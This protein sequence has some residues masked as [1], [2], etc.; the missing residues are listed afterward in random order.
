MKVCVYTLALVSAVAVYAPY[1][2]AATLN[3][4]APVTISTGSVTPAMFAVGDFNGD[5]KPDI[6]VPDQ[7]GVTVLVYLNQGRGTFSA[8]V[9]TTL[10]IPNTLGAILAGDFNED[11]K[12]DLLVSTVAGPQVAMPLLSNGDGTFTPQPGIAGSFGFLGG[13]VIDL[14]GDGHKD[15]VL[16]GNGTPYVFFGK[17]DGTFTQQSIPAGSFPGDYFSITVG[18]FRGTKN[19]DVVMA[20]TGD[21][22]GQAGSIDV[23]PGAAGGTLTARTSYTPILITHPETLDSADFNGDGK[24]DLLI[25]G[26]IGTFVAFG[27]GDGTFQFG[28]S[29]LIYLAGSNATPA[30]MSAVVA[31]LNQDGKPDAIVVD[32][33]SGFL[34]LF[35]NDGTGTFPDA[36]V[37]PYTFQLPADSYTIAAADLNG[38]GLPDIIAS[39]KGSRSLTIILSSKTLVT[40]TLSLTSPNASVLA[41]TAITFNASVTGGSS[42]PTGTVTLQDGSSTIGQKALDSSGAAVFT[43]SNLAVGSHA[44]SFNYPGDGNFAAATSSTFNQSVTDFEIGISPATQTIAAGSSATYTLTITPEAGF[45]GPV[46]L[47]CSGAP[48]LA[49][50][51]VP[52]VNI[53]GAPATATVTITTTA[54]TTA[55][56]ASHHDAIYACALFGCVV[57]VFFRRG[58]A[59]H[60][61]ISVVVLL[62][63]GALIAA[64]LTACGSGSSKTAVPGTPSGTS[65]ITLTASTTQ[66]GVTITHNATGSLTVQ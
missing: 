28:N 23:F 34:S 10:N 30:Y 60:S 45:T 66:G 16:G 22:S 41:G 59:L 55:A 24:L 54:T 39:S 31:D 11:G 61:G 3:Y 20:D 32:G 29:Q 35:V 7:A 64:T 19:S 57:F 50:C 4:Q 9:V 44:I 27:N 18:D 43:I 65:T 42:I 6:A 51:V 62:S 49:K 56:L 52:A 53:S 47:A 1:C 63:S 13:E 25:A 2:H 12:D 40:P 21:P 48:S 15:L 33:Q 14:N 26:S 17:G 58:R 8:P 5:G 46:T 36:A 37:T 38:D